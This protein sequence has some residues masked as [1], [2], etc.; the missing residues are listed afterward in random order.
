MAAK[1]IPVKVKKI[2]PAKPTVSDSI[3]EEKDFQNKEEVALHQEDQKLKDTTVSKTNRKR[4]YNSQ[5]R[6]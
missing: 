1:E 2:N 5:G 4:I 6:R 3:K